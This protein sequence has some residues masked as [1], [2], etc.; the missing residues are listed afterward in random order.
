M[1]Q[2]T[3]VSCFALHPPHC[4]S[5]WWHCRPRLSLCH[6]QM[7]RFQTRSGQ[8]Q[9]TRSWPSRLQGMKHL[10]FRIQHFILSTRE[11]FR[12]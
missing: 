4:H 6:Q 7:R 3:Y 10:L 8:R 5:P 9:G 12:N 11:A 1:A 2:G